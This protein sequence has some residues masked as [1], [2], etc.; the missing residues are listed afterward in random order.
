MLGNFAQ[1]DAP[2]QRPGGR[3]VGQRWRRRL[4]GQRHAK[5][6][7]PNAEAMGVHSSSSRDGTRPAE[8]HRKSPICQRPFVH[9]VCSRT[10]ERLRD[11]NVPCDHRMSSRKRAPGTP[12][13]RSPSEQRSRVEIRQSAIGTSGRARTPQQRWTVRVDLGNETPGTQ[14]HRDVSGGGTKTI[15]NQQLRN[16]ELTS[17]D[18][19]R[20]WEETNTETRS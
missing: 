1:D 6:E 9:R 2:L 7:R 13:H 8:M 3:E 12:L 17:A 10:L 16:V 20:T 11:A 5:R 15:G 14:P 18:R 19:A 4:F